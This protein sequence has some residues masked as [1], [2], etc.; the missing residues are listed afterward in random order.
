[1]PLVWLGSRCGIVNDALPDTPFGAEQ[2][3]TYC[4]DGD[5][6]EVAC[7]ASEFWDDDAEELEEDE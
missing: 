6:L 3:C 4:T 7:D 5:C 2:E 1:M